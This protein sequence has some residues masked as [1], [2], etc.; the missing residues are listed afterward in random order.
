MQ[1]GREHDPQHGVEAG[2]GGTF[3][4]SV[5]AL[6]AGGLLIAVALGAA[7]YRLWPKDSAWDH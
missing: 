3:S 5:P 4:D 7:A 2:A 6:V 1:N